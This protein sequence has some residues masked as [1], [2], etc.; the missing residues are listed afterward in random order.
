[1]VTESPSKPELVSKRVAGEINC[2]CDKEYSHPDPIFLRNHCPQR[3]V[4]GI[5]GKD[6]SMQSSCILVSRT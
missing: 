5:I 1:M 6:V 4:L 2:R 3:T